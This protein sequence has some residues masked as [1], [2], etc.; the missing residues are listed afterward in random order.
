VRISKLFLCVG[1]ALL[2]ASAALAQ[3]P[4]SSHVVVVAEENHSYSS[5][6]PASMP[7]LYSLAT[8]YGMATNFYANTHPSIGNYL[9]LTAG[10]I[11]TNNDGYSGTVNVDNIV[12]HLLTS[13]LSWKSYAENLP[14]VGYTGGDSYPYIKHHNPLAYFTDVANSSQKLNLVPFTQFAA[15]LKANNL[16]NFSFVVPNQLHNAHDASLNAADA[17]LAAN[18]APLLATPQFQTDGL[19]VVWFDEGFAN[20]TANG[21]G[22]T[23]VAMIG[24]KVTP[25]VKGTGFYQHQNLLRTISEALGMTSSPGAA[26]GVKDMGEFFGAAGP[27]PPPPPPSVCKL[28]TVSPSVTICAPASNGSVGSPVAVKAGATDSSPVRLV[29]VYV[30]GVKKY[31]T[32]GNAVNTALALPAGTHRFAVQAFDNAGRVFK[33]V[34]YATVK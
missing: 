4:H 5:V 12:R 27:P 22:H 20:D 8:K 9:M 10:Q 3:V 6:T 18:I 15:D 24:P 13:G 7:Y 33:S 23:F 28:S 31:E 34:V 17:W 26:A 1:M 16:P 21:G 14:G 30:D 29:Q 19:L 32:A 11:I 25:G 2:L